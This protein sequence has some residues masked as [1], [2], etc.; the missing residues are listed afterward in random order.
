MGLF[1]DISTAIDFYNDILH[2]NIDPVM[3]REFYP[4]NQSESSSMDDFLRTPEEW[5]RLCHL[6]NYY[7]AILMAVC[8]ISCVVGNG[9]TLPT[10]ARQSKRLG[11]TPT[12]FLFQAMAVADLCVLIPISI[13]G[14]YP[15]ICRVT[16]EMTGPCKTFHQQYLAWLIAYFWPLGP[17]G[18]VASV[19]I[20]VAVTYHR[21]RA[22]C[23]PF[24][25]NNGSSNPMSVVYL[26]VAA[27]WAFS[28]LYNLPR[29]FEFYVIPSVNAANE[30]IYEFHHSDLFLNQMYQTIYKSLSFFILI[31]VIP[32]TVISVLTCRLV[33]ALRNAES[34]QRGMSASSRA[35]PRRSQRERSLTLTLIVVVI[36]F[37]VCQTPTAINRI[38]TAIIG[39]PGCQHWL[40]YY[41]VICN[42]LININSS[43][44]FYVY[45]SCS[46]SFRH[47]LKMLLTCGRGRCCGPK[48]TDTTTEYGYDTRYSR[49]DSRRDSCIQD[50]RIATVCEQVE[51]GMREDSSSSHEGIG[52]K[53][54]EDGSYNTDMTEKWMTT[55]NNNANTTK[56]DIN[57]MNDSNEMEESNINDLN[58]L[59]GDGEKISCDKSV[60]SGLEIMDLNMFEQSTNGIGREENNDLT[61]KD[62][63]VN[64]PRVM[65]TAMETSS[66]Q[67]CG[68]NGYDGVNPVIS[69]RL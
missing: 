55:Y 40:W 23:T 59:K 69:T 10:F 38:L 1:P 29:F 19:W 20:T 57:T 15:D 62:L 25:V 16:T 49:Y 48:L 36:I 13:V 8:A 44:N 65:K 42:L 11:P 32:L 43:V 56:E 14:I 37:F 47:H 18:Q 50:T 64:E 58:L 66:Q 12:I 53:E 39:P 54:M 41:I 3:N 24:L 68:G 45:T 17:M 52:N 7:V 63:N 27:I 35:R 51:G 67:S 30:S 33:K 2:N 6:F 4:D 61:E 22:V 28:I 26:H 5:Y 46:S 34:A 31:N 9:L 60:D 21:Y